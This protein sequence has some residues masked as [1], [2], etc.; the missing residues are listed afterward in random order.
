MNQPYNVL[1]YHQMTQLDAWWKTF[2]TTVIKFWHNLTIPIF[3]LWL[4]AEIWYFSFVKCWT[5]LESCA[6]SED[7]LDKYSQMWVAGIF[8]AHN[9][10][11]QGEVMF[12][13]GI[14]DN[15]ALIQ[16][17]LTTRTGFIHWNL[18]RYKSILTI[19]SIRND[20]H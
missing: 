5:N 16:Y 19:N 15:I 3:K 1:E 12:L 13:N 6:V 14:R 11:P 4:N 8:T 18:I 2:N 9:T 7:I 20:K 10:D 17:T